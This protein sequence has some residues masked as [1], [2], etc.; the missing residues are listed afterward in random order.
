MSAHQQK[1][2]RLE[3]MLDVVDQIR[4]ANERDDHGLSE[5]LNERLRLLLAES[6]ERLLK[7]RELAEWRFSAH[8]KP[9]SDARAE[10]ALGELRAAVLALGPTP[11]WH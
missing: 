3:R 9:E 6:P 7:T 1:L 11:S 4:Q 8:T 2:G 10:A 5:K